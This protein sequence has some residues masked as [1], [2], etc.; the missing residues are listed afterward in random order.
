MNRNAF[1]AL[2]RFAVAN[3]KTNEVLQAFKNRPH[4]V[5]NVEGFIK[6]DVIRPQEDPHEFW[7]IT[8][9]QDE[10][11]FKQWHKSHTYHDSHDGIPKG[12][13]LDPS[14]T[15]LTFFEHIAS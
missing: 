11:C 2:S 1:V 7:L 3:D 15:S 6:M 4:F 5:D 9:W 12:L 14:K 13:K 8:Y 10:M